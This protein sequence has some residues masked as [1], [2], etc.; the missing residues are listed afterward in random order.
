MADP[1]FAF[2]DLLGAT[3]AALLVDGNGL[4]LA[5]AY[6]AQDGRDVAS[7]ISAA[8]S[9]VSEQAFRATRHLGIG[10]WRSIT[11]ETEHA[12]VALSPCQ[13]EARSDEGSAGAFSQSLLVVATASGTP[14]GAFARTVSRCQTRATSL[15]EG[16]DA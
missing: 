10:D 6:D 7:E 13:S 14:L 2:A 5:G 15:L 9:G 12:T 1:R 3:D 16:G 8:L 11:F 4:V